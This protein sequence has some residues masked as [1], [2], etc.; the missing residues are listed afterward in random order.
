MRAALNG[1]VLVIDGVEKAERNVLPILNSLLE[2]REMQLDDGR[3]L[4][5][6]HKY[7]ALVQVFIIILFRIL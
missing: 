5:P 6:A 4:I 3:F 2:S 7:D 1:R